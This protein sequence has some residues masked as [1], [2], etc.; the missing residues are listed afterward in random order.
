M[1]KSVMFGL[2][3]TISVVSVACIGAVVPIAYP[4]PISVILGTIVVVLSVAWLLYRAF[5]PPAPDPITAAAGAVFPDGFKWKQEALMAVGGGNV[6]DGLIWKERER[7]LES[8]EYGSLDSRFVTWPDFRDPKINRLLHSALT[9]FVL[10]PVNRNDQLDDYLKGWKH[11]PDRKEGADVDAEIGGRIWFEPHFA[12]QASPK[13]SFE[14]MR[15]RRDEIRGIIQ[16][17]FENVNG[18]VHI[19]SASN[20]ATAFFTQ[21]DVQGLVGAEAL[22]YR[23][24]MILYVDDR[25]RPGRVDDYIEATAG[26][27]KKFTDRI[28]HDN[29]YFPILLTDNRTH[30]NQKL[31]HMALILM[32]A[33]AAASGGNEG[34][35]YKLLTLASVYAPFVPKR[36]TVRNLRSVLARQEWANL[37]AAMDPEIWPCLWTGFDASIPA[38]YREGIVVIMAGDER[39]CAGVFVCIQSALRSKDIDSSV[40]I[41]HVPGAETIW[42]AACV[43]LTKSELEISQMAPVFMPLAKPGPNQ[44]DGPATLLDEGLPL[45]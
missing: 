21:I 14:R 3:A 10:T 43:P 37:L 33:G 41:A 17:N 12:G 45:S 35:P 7:V 36:Q 40:I 6:S 31:D 29:Q 32:L 22:E 1:N 28:V 18:V 19:V 42:M 16:D 2:P 25:I 13:E 34:D 23:N 9:G 39:E 15:M 24:H 30:N 38:A 11:P 20:S 26:E 5:Q 27:I 4:H 44:A 8:Q